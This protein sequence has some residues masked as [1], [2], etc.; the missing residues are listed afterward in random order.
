MM[1]LQKRQLNC[2]HGTQCNG[3]GFQKSAKN[4]LERMSINIS[5]RNFEIL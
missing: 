2:K 3:L 5:T 4:I 1:D